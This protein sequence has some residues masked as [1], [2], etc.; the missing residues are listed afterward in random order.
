MARRR[1]LI[2]AIGLLVVIGL[3]TSL[4]GTAWPTMRIEFDRPIQDLGLLALLGV[5]TGSVS[6][7][8]SGS[9]ARRFGLRRLLMAGPVLAVGGLVGIAMAPSWM[10]L[11]TASVVLSFGWG[12]I[13]PGVNSHVA[14]EHG[15]R[16]M[17]LLHATFGVGAVFGPILMARSLSGF[18][19]WRPAYVVSAVAVMIAVGA[20]MVTRHQWRAPQVDQDDSRGRTPSL[21]PTVPY[22][23][24]FLLAVAVELSMGQ[25][26]F[27]ILEDRGMALEPAARFVAAYWGGL[28]LGRL[29]GV[30]F[31]QA[32][33]YRVKLA[34][35]SAALIV[36]LAWF[37]A[38][39]GGLGAWSLPLAGIG[40]AL[41]FPT[42]VSVSARGFGDQT[43]YVIGWSFAAAGV[44][45]GVGPWLVGEIGARAGLHIIPWLVL[46]FVVLLAGISNVAASDAE[47]LAAHRAA[48]EQAYGR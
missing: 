16:A 11:V 6:S 27:S 47:R 29:S 3:T 7:A 25:W 39:P 32:V 20:V 17:N 35:S 30:F 18:G 46:G 28:T 36:G 22:L 23:A 2:I 26:S 38:D 12:L 21:G 41:V 10:V 43:D 13:D 37:G 45:A 4:I 48:A 40:I 33:P 8:L 34:I 9:M 44:G 5:A 15:P 19:D 24:A 42:M 31:G 1:L 14:L